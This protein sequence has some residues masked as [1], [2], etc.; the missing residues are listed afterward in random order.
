M[1]RNG[2]DI[3]ADGWID[4]SVSNTP[5]QK[6]R[7]MKKMNFGSWLLAVEERQ[8]IIDLKRRVRTVNERLH[9]FQLIWWMRRLTPLA[10]IKS[11]VVR[12]PTMSEEFQQAIIGLRIATI[13]E[14]NH[15]FGFDDVSAVDLI[16]F[17]YD[18]GAYTATL[19]RVGRN[20]IVAEIEWN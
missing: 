6:D 20:I 11:I 19:V 13:D 17:R 2:M 16:S 9:M 18:M 12:H 14:N 1:M 7:A 3:L 4:W 15:V 10:L 5:R 8:R